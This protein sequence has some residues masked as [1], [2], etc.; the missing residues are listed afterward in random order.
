M[1]T[2]LQSGERNEKCLDIAR[3]E[4]NSIER[5]FEE[6]QEKYHE[7]ERNFHSALTGEDRLQEKIR[8]MTQQMKCEIDSNTEVLEMYKDAE[9]KIS[10]LEERLQT[11]NDELNQVTRDL[12]RKDEENSL[13]K[14]VWDFVDNSGLIKWNYDKTDFHN[15][16]GASASLIDYSLAG[17]ITAFNINSDDTSLTSIES[18]PKTSTVI[19]H[20]KNRRKTVIYRKPCRR[21]SLFAEMEVS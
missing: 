11:L 6:L 14:Q 5:R 1:D 10:N 9:V 12:V 3:H 20:R 17:E 16:E 7:L 4:R 18:T 15:H 19:R 13:L 21:R 8:R 2:I